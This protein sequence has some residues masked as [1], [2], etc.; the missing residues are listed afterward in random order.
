MTVKA[1]PVP[2][3]HSD[4]KLRIISFNLRCTGEGDTSVETRYPLMCAQLLEFAPDSMG[5]QEA[6]PQWMELLKEELKDKYGFVGVGRDDGKNKGEYGPVFYL[7]DKY[8]LLDSG[9]IWLSA[10]P[11]KAGSRFLG[12]ACVRICTWVVLKN[13]ESGETYSHINTHLDHVS[14]KARLK[15]T[16]VLLKKIGELKKYGPIVCTGDFNVYENSDVYRKMCDN[17]TDAKYAAPVTENHGT[18]H[19]YRN[20]NLEGVSPIDFAF[21]ANGFEALTYRVI[22][23]KINGLH[24]SDHYGLSVELK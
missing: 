18:F 5:L 7:K 16:D 15:Q 20:D 14:E 24:L 13:K 2:E 22:K 6:T 12:S 9:T 10:K 4:A 3:M 1:N 17:M 11:N 21:I 8:E 19:A 23:D